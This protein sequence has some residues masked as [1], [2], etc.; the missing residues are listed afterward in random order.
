[1]KPK[2]LFDK[3]LKMSPPSFKEIISQ[4]I[5]N[6]LISLNEIIV[7]KFF[8]VINQDYEKA[9]ICLDFEKQLCQVQAQCLFDI[10]ILQKRYGE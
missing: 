5:I 4:K 7:L 2:F 1:M 10:G 3:Y 9:A 8:M 6:N